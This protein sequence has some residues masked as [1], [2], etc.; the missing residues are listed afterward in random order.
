MSRTARVIVV[1]SSC[2]VA[3]TACAA[4]VE[5]THEPRFTSFSSRLPPARPGYPATPAWGSLAGATISGHD[6]MFTFTEPA[7]QPGQVVVQI[8]AID[9]IEYLTSRTCGDSPR[10][11]DKVI[12]EYFREPACDVQA[13]LM[14]AEMAC[15]ER[16]KAYVSVGT[17]PVA[18]SPAPI[19]SGQNVGVLDPAYIKSLSFSQKISFAGEVMDNVFVEW[20]AQ[21]D[22][23]G[24]HPTA[25]TTPCRSV[26]C[27]ELWSR[28]VGAAAIGPPG[29]GTKR[30]WSERGQSW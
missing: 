4:P 19:T 23:D 27:L 18:P 22:Y 11:F 28:S 17:L 8:I 12:V 9:G 3:V 30:T 20:G 21:Y 6:Y 16:K 13:R 10:T 2:V 1:L 24:C 26:H 15:L 7:R 5:L 29:P 25:P 14:A